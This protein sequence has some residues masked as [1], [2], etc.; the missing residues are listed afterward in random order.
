MTLLYAKIGL[1]PKFLCNF[2]V[3]YKKDN[4]DDNDK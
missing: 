4:K 3:C 2:A 1:G